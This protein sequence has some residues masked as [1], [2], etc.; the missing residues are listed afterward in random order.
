[1]KIDNTRSQIFRIAYRLWS[2]ASVAAD[3]MCCL[4]GQK[5]RRFIP[6][7]GAWSGMPSVLTEAGVVGSDIANF[8]CPACGCHDRERHLYLYLKATGLLASM[9]SARILHLAPETHLQRVIAQAGPRDYVLGDLY[10]SRPQVQR[11]DLMDIELPDS[12]LDFVIANHVLEHVQDDVQA[13]RE[14]H[15]VLRP[16]GCAILQTPFAS[17]NEHK[18]EDTGITSEVG[19]LKAYGQED[20]CRLYGAD[21]SDFVASH[22]FIDRTA[23]HAELLPDVDPFR[24]GVN[25]REPFLY[26]MKPLA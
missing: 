1:M 18:F 20:H 21:F 10:P 16:G 5:V 11:I 8:E 6:Y 24:M 17:L 4:C 14:I 13:L 19:R 15:R 22:G 3:R 25:P 26:F 9:A 7:R 2:L 12:Q 23:T